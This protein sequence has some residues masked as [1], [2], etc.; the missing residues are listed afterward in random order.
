MNTKSDQL[1]DEAD[2]AHEPQASMRV[3]LIEDDAETATFV[4]GG[5]KE[6]GYEVEQIGTGREGLVKAA[7][8]NYHVLVIDRM[9]PGLDGL[10]IVKT[11]RAA[12]VET[13][14]IFLTTMSGIDD[15]VEGLRAGGDDYLVKP[16]ALEE[17]LARI[18]VLTRRPAGSD[19]RTKLRLA[20]L[21]MDLLKRT[22]TRSRRIIDLQ[23]QEFKL[24]EYLL[25]N[26]GRPVTRTML[27]EKVWDF[28]FEPQTSVIETHISRLR[29]KVDR[30][31][32]VQLI[33][34]VRGSG[35]CLSVGS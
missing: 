26:A 4:A 34:T 16:F 33:H 8:G 28:H 35:Y 30:N 17:L 31:F 2:G 1:V 27:L 23:P 20:D 18:A 7:A 3:L 24:L 15:R 9:L 21:E 22:V 19:V 14:V 29:S 12:A 25:K 11:L 10:G 32:A 6:E 5:L 13:P